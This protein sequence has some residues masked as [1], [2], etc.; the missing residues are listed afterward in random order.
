MSI[1]T[2]RNI[3]VCFNPVGT[4]YRPR[5]ISGAD[6][7][8][9]AR[10]CGISDLEGARLERAL[11][12]SIIHFTFD[13]KRTDTAS[14]TQSFLRPGGKSWWRNVVN[15]AIKRAL[16]PG[17]DIPADLFPTLFALVSAAE[18]FALGERDLPK[19]LG[20]LRR[21]FDPSSS[22]GR[23][24]SVDKLVVGVAE[25]VRHPRNL[26]RTSRVL[27]A[28]GISVAPLRYHHYAG[29]H[30][31][32]AADGEVPDE[33]YQSEQRKVAQRALADSIRR[34]SLRFG[35]NRSSLMRPYDLDFIC[36]TRNF[37]SGD[38]VP[39]L[40]AAERL[41]AMMVT[42]K[43][44]SRLPWAESQISR[45]DG[46]WLKLYVLKNS[47][48][49]TRNIIK[50]GW[51]PVLLEDNSDTD[52]SAR[53]ATPRRPDWESLSKLSDTKLDPDSPSG[54]KLQTYRADSVDELSRWLAEEI[55]PK[56]FVLGPRIV[57]AK[58]FRVLD[59]PDVEPNVPG[60]KSEDIL[61][62]VLEQRLK[63][64]PAIQKTGTSK[65]RVLALLERMV[66]GRLSQN[67]TPSHRRRGGQEDSG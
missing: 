10:K 44:P 67:T 41:A 1:R 53:G 42:N 47:N 48:K 63:R 60:L 12:D 20:R 26:E 64:R 17:R 57:K 8:G 59:D 50:S 13:E 43:S 40:R 39:S 37:A 7:T 65:E 49:D 62:K 33:I 4:L 30:T 3:L 2:K 29:L 32:Y 58:A 55:Q 16:R 6:Y 28:L 19:S 52:R 11:A 25:N 9:L 31:N 36:A 51:T 21:T 61:K 22:S 15:H 24:S 27:S 5:P 18:G 14:E 38:P 56:R 34:G 46:D 35:G 45:H 54:C 66:K 23:N